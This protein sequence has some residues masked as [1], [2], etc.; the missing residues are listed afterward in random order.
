MGFRLHVTHYRPVN[1]EIFSI[2]I[3]VSEFI[4]VFP[5]HWAI[6]RWDSY[7]LFYLPEDL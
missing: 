2:V 1:A 5:A 3:E 7:R 4:I 6:C